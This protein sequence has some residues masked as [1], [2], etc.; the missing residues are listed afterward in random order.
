[1]KKILTNLKEET[2]VEML[3][4]VFRTTLAYNDQL[5]LCHFR[6]KKGTQI[7]LHHHA[8]VQIGYLISGKIE[9]LSPD[10]GH[11]AIEAG[12]SYAI[13]S[14]EVHGANGL[15]DSEYVETFYPVRPEYYPDR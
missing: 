12:A 2:A 4:G 14:E 5:M 15:E 11:R 8:A 6:I 3:P 7:P 1:M 13:D 10:G 9:L